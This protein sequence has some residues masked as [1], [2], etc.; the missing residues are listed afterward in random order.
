MRF[1]ELQIGGLC[2]GI[3]AALLITFEAF[4]GIFEF[5]RSH[6]DWDLDEVIMLGISLIFGG[7][8][9]LWLIA[10]RQAHDM[11]QAQADILKSRDEAEF[12]N[13][14]KS[15]FLSNMSHELRTPLNSVIGF[16]HILKDDVD[17][18]LS[19]DQLNSVEHIN[20][21]GSHLL[22][23]INEV[24]DLSKIEAGTLGLNMEDCD[25]QTL[26]GQCIEL[27]EAQATEADVSVTLTSSTDLVV[28]ADHQRLTQSVLNL[29]TNGIKYNQPGGQAEIEAGKTS[30]AMI[31]ISV[32]DNGIGIARERFGELFE[33]FNRLGH[34]DSAIEGTGIGLAI[35][36][37]LIEAMDGSISV[38]STPG[39]GS[40]F[41]IHI[42]VA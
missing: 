10:R 22:A 36:D 4:E 20:K 35:V 30:D 32:S 27:V 15:D 9:Y 26:L 25:L 7:L 33:P 37:K 17:Q 31:S 39:E 2:F 6:E 29:L 40:T 16:S 28:R 5:T 34:E 18:P 1:V 13:K 11:K 42:P 24:L 19:E 21:A 3:L 41:T 12:A 8:I 38:K 23:L 14:A